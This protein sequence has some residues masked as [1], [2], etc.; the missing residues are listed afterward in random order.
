MTDQ[1]TTTEQPTVPLSVFDTARRMYHPSVQ[2]V[3]IG[4]YASGFMEGW[5]LRQDADS[6][7][8]RGGSQTWR[9]KLQPSP[10][11]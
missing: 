9:V 1:P 11:T 10:R 6:R 5:N 3:A 8:V 4:W 7:P 2:G